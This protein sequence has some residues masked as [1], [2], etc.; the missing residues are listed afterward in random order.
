M[1]MPVLPKSNVGA[2][3]RWSIH[4]GIHQHLP[5]CHSSGLCRNETQRR[6]LQSLFQIMCIETED[7]V[8]IT[9]MLTIEALVP[10]LARNFA[11]H[12]ESRRQELLESGQ[13]LAAADQQGLSAQHMEQ[14]VLAGTQS[15]LLGSGV[16]LPHIA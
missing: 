12:Q 3:Q 5:I 16:W 2:L 1:I 14:A 4:S 15:E 10:L 9:G 7:G 13:S 8:R 11:Q 6:Q